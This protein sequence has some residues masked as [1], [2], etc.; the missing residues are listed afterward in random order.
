MYLRLRQVCPETLVSPVVKIFMWTIEFGQKPEHKMFSSGFSQE[1][2]NQLSL[3]FRLNF[4][5]I[6]D[7][8][9]GGLDFSGG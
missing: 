1:Q 2:M 5:S 8:V 6:A 3:D 9:T 4:M 7:E